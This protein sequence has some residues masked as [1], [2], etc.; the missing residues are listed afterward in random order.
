MSE[1]QHIT[2]SFIQYSRMRTV[3]IQLALYI[4]I[5]FHKKHDMEKLIYISTICFSLLISQSLF[6]QKERKIEFPDIPGY[7]TLKTDFHI[8]T[9]FSDGSVW[10]DIRIQEAVRD[11]LDAISLTEHLEYQP[12]EKDIP[13]PDRNRSYHIATELA[14]PH[15]LIIIHGTEITKDLPPG[16]A[17]ALFISD[18]NKINI[19][20]PGKA[21]EAA[22]EQGA[23]VFWNH[24]NWINQ[25][26]DGKVVLTEMHQ[27]LVNKNLLHGI[28]V[29]ND[30]TYSDDALQ[31]A[32]ENNLAVMGTSDIHGLVDWQY[33]LAD[34]GHRPITLVFAKERTEESI[35][36]ALFAGRTVA[37][38][39]NILIG[40][41]E[42]LSELI[43]ASLETS[44]ASYI[45][46][47]SVAK[48]TIKNNSHASYI[49]KN[50]SEF[51]FQSHGDILE[52]PA[53]SKQIISVMTNEHL[54]SFNLSFEVMNAIV[55]KRKHPLINIK[56]M[57]K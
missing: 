57:T 13:H 18:A 29:V 46:P 20:D 34:G 44:T 27:E 49:L 19:K 53:Q 4:C 7:L 36:E 14:K 55:G 8:H 12:H 37:W 15:D 16:H 26:E 23:F 33:R 38:F 50:K 40:K 25:K 2:T 9:V 45:G 22:H 11:G 21:Y 56:L 41:E 10:P 1:Y 51:D 39:E 17:N 3:H 32:L 31:V 35:Q 24:P 30:L 54:S 28:E 43:T 6:S 48:L 5:I 52:I 42:F 47:S